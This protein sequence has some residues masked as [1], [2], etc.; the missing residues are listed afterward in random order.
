MRIAILGVGSIGG[1]VLGALSDTDADLVAVSRGQAASNLEMVGLIQPCGEVWGP[2][3]Q[4]K[5][6]GF[7]S[8]FQVDW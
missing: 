5:L 2:P 1:L 7:P 6:L 8:D 4:R 3:F